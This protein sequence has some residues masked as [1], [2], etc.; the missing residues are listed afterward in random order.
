MPAICVGGCAIV[1]ILYVLPCWQVGTMAF[2]PAVLAGGY[3][4]DLLLTIAFDGETWDEARIGKYVQLFTLSCSISKTGA[5]NPR[6]VF[7]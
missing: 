5:L 3:V 1:T 6:R 2:E 7:S 4:T